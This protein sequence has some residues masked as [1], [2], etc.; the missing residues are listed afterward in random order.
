[1]RFHFILTVLL[2]VPEGTSYITIEGT[3]TLTPGATRQTAYS[4]LLILLR[5][6]HNLPPETRLNTVFFALEPNELPG[7]THAVA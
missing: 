4:N 1:M 6:R 3:T 5:S 2:P 7:V